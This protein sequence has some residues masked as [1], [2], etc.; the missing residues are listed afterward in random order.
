MGLPSGLSQNRHGGAT[1]APSLFGHLIVTRVEIFL[2]LSKS[3]LEEGRMTSS[4][5]WSSSYGRKL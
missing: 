4:S 2:T 1:Q 5:K 3:L